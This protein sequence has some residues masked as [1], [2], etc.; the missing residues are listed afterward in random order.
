MKPNLILQLLCLFIL[1]CHSP[2]KQEG[3]NQ[4]PSVNKIDS[5]NKEYL[6]WNTVRLNGTIPMITNYKDV[7]S[8]LGMPDSIGKLSA[9]VNGSFY[10]KKFQECYFKGLAF[11]KYSDTLVFSKIDFRKAKAAY[12]GDN[13]IM[14]GSTSTDSYFHKLF[15]YSFLNTELTG[16]DMD[17]YLFISLPTSSKNTSDG[18][19]FTF[20][21]ETG[22]LLSIEHSDTPNSQTQ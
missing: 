20:E 19:I 15:P 12:L 8:K 10:H 9:G 11:E 3:S 14:F 22:A 7:V 5:S 17:K 16:T 18:W 1:A 13:K 4:S 21:L 6:D 2:K